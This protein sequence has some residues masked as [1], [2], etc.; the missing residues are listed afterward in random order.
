[1]TINEQQPRAS[2]SG[3][4]DKVRAHL[5]TVGLKNISNI[6]H[7]PSYDTLF[8]AETDGS[9]TGYEKGTVTDSGAINVD[10]GICVCYYAQCFLN[11]APNF[12]RPR[13]QVIHIISGTFS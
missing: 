11:L 3:R 13:R 10:T 2:Q 1:M 8:A 5:E 12:D 7:N 9:L 6:I 4:L